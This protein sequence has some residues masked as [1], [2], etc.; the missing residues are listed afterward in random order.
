M[1]NEFDM[2]N[3]FYSTVSQIHTYHQIKNNLQWYEK[4]NPIISHKMKM[5]RTKILEQIES[6]IVNYDSIDKRFMK[7]FQIMY[8]S[9][10][11][12]MNQDNVSYIRFSNQYIDIDHIQQ[13]IFY[14]MM[15]QNR[16][17]V[18]ILSD[19]I[20]VCD[21]FENMTYNGENHIPDS[22]TWLKNVIDIIKHC[23][24]LYFIDFLEKK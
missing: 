14:Q 16:Y 20:T 8:L 18:D 15:F 7:D 13:S 9:N 22:E 17:M 1:E 4:I 19:S 10:I 21:T 23:I 5:I 2:E 3:I 24:L 11:E 12:Y 6:I